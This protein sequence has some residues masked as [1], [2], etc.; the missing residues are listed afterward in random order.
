MKCPMKE[1]F[2]EM[3]E[4]QITHTFIRNGKPFVVEGIP[5]HVCPICGYT[6]LE[7]KILD[8]LLSFDPKKNRPV[9]QAPVYRIDVKKVP[10]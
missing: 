10:A 5:A 4:K 8:Q 3:E 2:G 1:C 6:V 7:L 9:G